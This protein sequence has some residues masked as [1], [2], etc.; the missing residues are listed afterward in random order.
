[1]L[2]SVFRNPEY[3]SELNIYRLLLGIGG[4]GMVVFGFI[5]IVALPGAYEIMYDRYIVGGLCLVGFVL[6]YLPGFKRNHIYLMTDVLFFVFTAQVFIANYNNGFRLPYILNLMMVMLVV[7]S[8]LRNLFSLT[9][10]I[11]FFLT[12]LFVSL[13]L[14]TEVSVGHKILLLVPYIMALVIGYFIQFIR[15]RGLARMELYDNFIRSIL[16]ETADAIFIADLGGHIIDSNQRLNEMLEISGEGMKGKHINSIL[17]EEMPLDDRI[18]TVREAKLGKV[19]GGNKL[20]KRSNGDLFWGDFAISTLKGPEQLFL[21]V[22]LTD[23]TEQK[24]V[25]QELQ[26]SQERYEAALE[27]AN[28][29]IW[30][31]DMVTN[32]VYFSTR[33]KEMLGYEDNEL[34]NSFA[35][36]EI[37]LHEEDKDSTIAALNDYLAKKTNKYAAEFRMLHKKGHYVWILARGK[38]M[39]NDKG[40]QIRMAGSHTDITERKEAEFLLK[41]VMDSALNGIMAYKSVRNAKGEIVDMQWVMLNNAAAKMM[42]RTVDYYL[43]KRMM[44]EA[45]KD[46]GEFFL[47]QYAHVVQNR[48]PLNIEHN[49]QFRGGISNWFHITAVPLGDGVAVTFTDINQRKNYEEQLK[50]AKEAAEAG[51]RAKAEFLATMSHEIRTPMNAVI[52]MTGL[53]LETPLTNAQQDYVETIRSGGDNLLAI[54]DD[55]LDY[56]KI[57]SGNLELEEH[58]FVLSECV[59]SVYDLLAPKARDKKLEL[60]YFIHPEVPERIIGD[61]V[62]IRQVLVNLVN[63]AIKFT[64]KGEILVTVEESLLNPDKKELVF[65]VKDTGIGIPEDKIE[66][67]FKL[68]SQVDSSTTRKYGGTGLGLAICKRLVNLMGGDVWVESE[69]SKGSVFYFNLPLKEALA[70]ELTEIEPKGSIFKDKRVLLVDDNHTN[71]RILSFQCTAWGMEPVAVDDPRK[72]LELIRHR[73]RFDLAIVD[74]QM[75]GM[76]GVQLVREIRK[77]YS[78]IELPIVILTSLGSF[79]NGEERKLI[80][81]FINKPAR[82]SQLL[83]HMRRALGGNPDAAEEDEKTIRSQAAVE[84]SARKEITIL[85][86]EDNVINQKVALGSLKVVGYEADIANNGLEV[87]EK[88]KTKHYDL[89]FMDVQM[90][91]MDGMEATAHIR[92]SNGNTPANPIIIAMTANAMQDDREK[93]LAAGMNDYISKPV[94]LDTIREVL[95]RWFSGH[96]E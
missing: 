11:I 13:S 49:F 10:Y 94:K 66:R 12:G 43:G 67:L 65:S 15:L 53:L 39:T 54:I 63:N 90:P 92:N 8:A 56:S 57:D 18:E 72:A 73:E 64:D 86:A 93:C 41:G 28:D 48:V 70:V 52:G 27:G 83:Y 69:D 2:N 20:C 9:F 58:P 75:P 80:S 50:A 1:M 29:G 78:I 68:F 87:L 24:R 59:E 34:E 96:S 95:N 44:Q 26:V 17:V 88:M 42:Y 7:I 77:I 47:R 32:R 62:R 22:R 74:M 60:L 81:A 46:E 71:L 40:E 14:C 25:E 35:E 91:E 21:L 51:A 19:T 85:V 23:I 45:V 84:L 6:T 76:D 61:P 37:R 4:I 36:W 30:D 33:Y 5:F 55:I 3:N 38:V 79:P 31:W 82:Q 89:I 16:N